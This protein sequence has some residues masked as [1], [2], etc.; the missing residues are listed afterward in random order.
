MPNTI[1]QPGY[2]PSSDTPDMWD[3]MLVEE[4]QANMAKQAEALPAEDAPSHAVIGRET[5]KVVQY[6][7][8]ALSPEEIQQQL[9]ERLN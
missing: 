8:Y 6:R 5:L 7:M 3:E 4:R 2:M 9:L 1:E